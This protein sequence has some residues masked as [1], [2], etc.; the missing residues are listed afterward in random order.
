MA[1][2]PRSALFQPGSRKEDEQAL[3]D[4][5]RRNKARKDGLG[6]V[7]KKNSKSDRDGVQ[8]RKDRGAFYGSWTDLSGHRRKRKLEASTLTQARTLISA[9]KMRVEKARTLGYVPPGNET[10]AEIMPRY[11]KHQKARITPQAYERTRGIVEGHLQQAF[12]STRLANI[13][14]MNIQHYITKRCSEVAPA[15]VVKE[16]NVLKHLFGLAV[17]WEIVPLNPCHR[18]K[19]PRVPAGRV[20]Y[21]QPTELRSVLDAC[22]DWLRPVIALL[23]ATGMRRGEVLGLRW[24]DVDLKGNR[25]LL[26]QTK[27]GEGR[28]VYL[29]RIACDALDSLPDGRPIDHVFSAQQGVTPEAVSMAFARACRSVGIE[30]F[31][32]HDLRHTAASWLRMQGADIHTVAQLLGHKDLRMAARYQHL[33]P[34]FLADAVAKLET[35]YQLTA[36]EDAHS[37]NPEEVEEA[38]SA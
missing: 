23:V 33:S 4:H 29:N 24:L 38:Q 17:D 10:L 11:L 32:L 5:S 13:R 15:S 19:P 7:P 18:I 16:L 34:A 21:L 31:R 36:P 35:A 37:G 30:D 8:W 20:R 28:I 25:I 22:A 26:P 3:Y 9:E 12:G 2:N 14:K 27:N 1:F 6:T